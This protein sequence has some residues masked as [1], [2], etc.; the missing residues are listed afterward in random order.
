MDKYLYELGLD[1][2][3]VGYKFLVDALYLLHVNKV[4]SLHIC[5]VYDFIGDKYGKSRQYVERSLQNL[6]RN[7]FLHKRKTK[8]QLMFILKNLQKQELI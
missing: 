3:K 4:L 7:S 8:D 2:N 6:F 1:D 5:R